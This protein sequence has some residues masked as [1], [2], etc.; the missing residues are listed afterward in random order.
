[1]RLRTGWNAMSVTTAQILTLATPSSGREVQ[2]GIRRVEGAIDT[3]LADAASLIGRTVRAGN[4]AGLAPAFTQRA[5]QRQ[6]AMIETAMKLR[7]LAFTCHN[8]LRTVLKRVDI[9]TVGWGD[10][11]SSPPAAMDDAVPPIATEAARA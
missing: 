10:L 9:D 3:M 5:L 7:E 1:M 6:T 11:G 4:E 2:D 8:D